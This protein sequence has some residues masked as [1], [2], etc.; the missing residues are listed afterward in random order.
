VS[1]RPIKSITKRFWTPIVALFF[2]LNGC[3]ATGPLF[4]SVNK[5][6]SD[7]STVYLF[8]K[9][10]FVGSAY[11]PVI[12][13]DGGDIGCLENGGFMRIKVGSGQHSIKVRRRLLEFGCGKPSEVTFITETNGVL[14]Y[15]WSTWLTSLGLV[16]GVG[17][18]CAGEAI[19]QH[20]ESEAIKI[21][22]GL[23]GSKYKAPD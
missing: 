2:L 14:F 15:E 4:Q 23:R 1:G 21:L 11:C 10:A 19:I 12:Q 17:W 7:Y 8:R 20:R 3:A 16:K 22:N 13:L 9:S 6:D 18:A 5:Y